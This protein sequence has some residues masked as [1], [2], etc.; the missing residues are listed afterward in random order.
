MRSAA[1]MEALGAKT[2]SRAAVAADPDPSLDAPPAFE[3]ANSF[4][5]RRDGCVFKSGDS[6]LG[7][8]ADAS[9][10]PAA[11][12]AAAAAASTEPIDPIEAARA[13]AAATTDAGVA[14]AAGDVPAL[15][16]LL[17]QGVDPNAL[18]PGEFRAGWLSAMLLQMVTPPGPKTV[19]G[20]FANALPSARAE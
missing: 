12:P 4:A 11:A 6:G 8:Y 9:Q 3:P 7:Y 1:K 18:L 17:G 2:E 20:E 14:A 5:G 16:R 10:Q 15:R 19:P 13:A